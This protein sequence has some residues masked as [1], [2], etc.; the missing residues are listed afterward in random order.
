MGAAFSFTLTGQRAAIDALAQVDKHAR[1]A[2]KTALRATG[3]KARMNVARAMS[4]QHNVPQ[5]LFKN[6]LRFFAPKRAGKRSAVTQ[7]RLWLGLSA[8]LRAGEHPRVKNAIKASHP[9]GFVPRLSSGHA[10]IFYRTKPTRKY[11][12]GARKHPRERHSLPIKEYGIDLRPG[13][14]ARLTQ[15]AKKAMR[16]TYPETFKKDYKRRIDRIRA[17]QKI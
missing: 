15:E 1:F 11:G 9:G 4:A 2:Q 14:K 5:K 7:A 8:T 10:G 12:P 16:T 17:K 6:R 3:R 13:A